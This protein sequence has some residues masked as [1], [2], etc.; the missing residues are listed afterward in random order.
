[1]RLSD[2]QPTATT[3][4]APEQEGGEAFKAPLANDRPTAMRGSDIESFQHID[5]TPDFQDGVFQTTPEQTAEWEQAGKIG[6]FEQWGRLDKSEML[7]FWGAGETAVKGFSILNAVNRIKDDKYDDEELRANDVE[8]VSNY[9]IRKEEERVRG[10][11]VPGKILSGVTQLPAFMLEFAATG[12]LAALGKAGV[13]K[14]AVLALKEGAEAGIGKLAT[15]LAV[16]VAEAGARTVG[17]PQR[18]AASY[19]DRQTRTNFQL[20]DKGVQ[21]RTEGQEKPMQSAFKAVGDVMIENYSEGAGEWIAKAGGALVPKALTSSMEKIFKRLHPTESVRKLWTKAGYHGFLAEMG[22]ERLGDL[23]RAITG[24][25]DFGAKNPD[26]VMDRVI[27]SIPTFEEMLVEAGVLA[28]PGA[29]QMATSEAVKMIRDGRGETVDNTREITEAEADEMAEKA[30]AKPVKENEGQDVQ[31]EVPP[32]FSEQDFQDVT[33]ESEEQQAE[34]DAM[35]KEA[36]E[37]IFKDAPEILAEPMNEA[38]E[39]MAIEQMLTEAE[40]DEVDERIAELGNVA[41]QSLQRISETPEFQEKEARVKELNGIL[42]GYALTRMTL[43]SIGKDA[44][45]TPEDQKAEKEAREELD[46][47]EAE[48]AKQNPAIQEAVK[49]I[50]ERQKGKRNFVRV[51]E[52]V[53]IRR[54]FQARF[55]GEK[56]GFSEG[57][58]EGKRQVESAKQILDKRR[59]MIQALREHYGFTDAELRRINRQDIRLMTDGEFLEFIRAIDARAVEFAKKRELKNQ[60]LN[61]INEKELKKVDNLRQ[62]LKFPTLDKMNVNQLN[63][64]NDL[65]VEAQHGDE[66]LPVRKLETVKNTELA[67][68]KTV[69]EAREILAKK[70]NV[71]VEKLENMKVGALDRY[72]FDAVLARQN[73]FYRY[74]VDETNQAILDGEQRFIEMERTVDELTNK[75][76]ASRKQSLADKLAPTDALVFEWLES[77]DKASVAK[78][79]TPEELNLAGYLQKRYAEFRDYLIK[80]NVLKKFRENYVTHIWRGFIEAWKADGPLKAFKEVFEQHKQESEIAKILD[81]DTQNILP[82]EKYFQFASARAKADSDM[83]IEPSKNVARAFKVYA[84]A[85]MKKQ[86]L[87]RIMPALDIYAHTLS[88]KRVTQTGLQMDRQLIKFVREWINN[89][90]GRRASFGSALQQN[91]KI[92]MA[93]R[94][95]NSFITMIDLGLNIPVGIA[96]QVGE[97]VSTFVNLGGKKYATGIQRMNTAK[98]K[99]ILKDNEAFVG[100]SP[101]KDLANAADEIGEKFGKILFS[102]FESSNVRANK[103]HLLGSLTNEEWESGKVSGQRLAELRREMGRYRMVHGA[104]SII[105]STSAGS[106]FTK[107]KTWALPILHTNISNLNELQKMIREGDF[108]KTVKSREFNELF[109]EALVSTFLV[110]AFKGMLPDEDD[111]SFL[112]TVLK[113]SYQD[114]HTMLGAMDPTMVVRVRMMGFLMDLATALKQ[115]ATLEEYK[116][117]EGYKGVDTFMRAI[118]P[119]A[120]RGILPKDEPKKKRQGGLV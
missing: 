26:N 55:K 107:Y 90:K 44:K 104:K 14:A 109:R 82:M 47:I 11:S 117:K 28:F 64:F 70:L 65:M 33:A 16:P 96:S 77:S 15:R 79:M 5:V 4:A 84:K 10:V 102:L 6:F 99:Q 36:D 49:N 115:I 116:T 91:G 110:L 75:A 54:L 37:I 86:S 52:K 30:K 62:Y 106:A 8:K 46:Q 108:A 2:I 1:M 73:D 29:A 40:R 63:E 12:G 35:R 61:E 98:G 92:D 112:S 118:T 7:P 22:E 43:E 111:G 94:S 87:D 48:V 38:E 71:P 101:F 21:L 56:I 34:F 88:P 27:G 42:D 83:R 114:A 13:K 93:L 59:N 18:L 78:R 31:I 24:V 32:D 9:L 105:G 69:R 76:R 89:K 50:T 81:D 19:A 41:A 120:V 53:L 57:I 25:E 68:I 67:G 23:L 66:F 20:T 72:R 58:E 95:I 85:I 113:K 97:Q 39:R 103:I 17:M 51:T 80:Q 3:T 119:K 45:L 60:I 74:L 100:R